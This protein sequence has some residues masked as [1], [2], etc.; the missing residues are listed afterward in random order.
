MR[1]APE[2]AARSSPLVSLTCGHYM[3]V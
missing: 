2:G 3:T 1:G